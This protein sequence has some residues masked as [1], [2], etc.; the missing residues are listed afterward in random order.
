MILKKNHRRLFRFVWMFLNRNWFENAGPEKTKHHSKMQLEIFYILDSGFR[1][2]FHFFC[3]VCVAFVTPFFAFVFIV[4]IFR[5]PAL[6]Y[7]ARRAWLVLCSRAF[8]WWCPAPV[9]GKGALLVKFQE[10]V[11]QQLPF[12]LTWKG[13]WHPCSNNSVLCFLFSAV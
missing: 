4:L 2:R 10:P 3:C 1:F 6:C 8:C 13:V 12:Q 7:L 9:H 5:W 11:L